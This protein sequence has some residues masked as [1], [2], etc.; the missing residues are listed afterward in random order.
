MQGI[1]KKLYDNLNNIVFPV[2]HEKSI[3]MDSGK[4]LAEELSEFNSSLN[5]KAKQVDVNN[6]LLLKANQTSLDTTNNNISNLQTQV[7]NM[8][9]GSPKGVY[10]SL[11]ALQTAFPSGTTGTY[12]VSADGK[13]YYWNGSA[14]AS[15]GIYQ[16]TGIVNRQITNDKLSD[17]SVDGYNVKF[18]NQSVNLFDVTAINTTGYYDKWGTFATNTTY[19][20]TDFIRVKPSTTYITD[21]G[22]INGFKG[23][24]AFWDINRQ[25]IL[26]V[27][28]AANGWTTTINVPANAYYITIAIKLSVSLTY[29][30]FVEGSILPTSYVAFGYNL[31]DVIKIPKSSL[32]TTEVNYD[33]LQFIQSDENFF[34]KTNYTTGGWY[35]KWGTWGTNADY[36][37]SHLV[38]VK[39]N[40]KYYIT[41][42]SV[43]G[44]IAFW[45]INRQPILGV[46]IA[47]NGWSGMVQVPNDARV[48]YLTFPFKPA[49]ENL[50]TLQ[51]RIGDIAPSDFLAFGFKRIMLNDAIIQT[52]SLELPSTI[53]LK[54]KDKSLLIFGDSITETA[55]VSD[56]GT[57]YTEGYYSSM[58]PAYAKDIL[59]VGQMWN[60]AKSG[61][62]YKNKNLLPR[63]FIGYQISTAIANN[64]PGDI[65]VVSAGT[66]DG[67]T[68]LGDYDTA[69]SK[70]T[71]ADLDT[72]LLYEA[73][74]WAFWTIRQNYPN[75]ICF[76][77]T[78]IQRADREPLPNLTQAIIKMANRYNFIVI[79][80]EKESGIVRDFEVWNATGRYLA[81]GLH[82]HT[83]GRILMA[84][85]YSSV[86]LNR[87]NC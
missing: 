32:P 40:T 46:G 86:I 45:D 21:I 51:V 85:Y 63:Q 28:I 9:S 4:S 31:K 83:A 19:G 58:W 66:N 48:A 5:K 62:S 87:M 72:T 68:Q 76:A 84:N 49:T 74:R 23:E 3:Y 35:D 47:A 7:S 16:S 1:I 30:M 57:T 44:D 36:A 64:R 34:D 82:P 61:A 65:I 33:N 71:L 6:A 70:A 78:P 77:A 12:V 54:T 53:T 52:K 10:A 80:A 18:L 41:V 73:I 13:W 42:T 37:S 38:K 60:Y 75:A 50:N 11:S 24:I 56:D 29:A 25:P 17:G 43:K 59:Q 27:G 8:G 69:M 55:L 20:S 14:W 26:G 79:D 15:G 2:T 81:D 67:D 39:P 22:T